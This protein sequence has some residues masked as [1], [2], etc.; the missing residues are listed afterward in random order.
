MSAINVP[1]VLA[2]LYGQLDDRQQRDL[3]E[4]LW[5]LDDVLDRQSRTDVA[6]AKK[7]VVVDEES[8]REHTRLHAHANGLLD[9]GDYL[10]AVA[11]SLEDGQ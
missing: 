6:E 8:S 7:L 2:R 9:A 3:V 10:R 1:E 11:K 5:Q 4:A